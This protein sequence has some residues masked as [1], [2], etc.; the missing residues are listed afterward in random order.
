VKAVSRRPFVL[1]EGSDQI[2]EIRAHANRLQMMCSEL[3]AALSDLLDETLSIAGGPRG[4]PPALLSVQ[5]CADVLGLS[6][7]TTFSLIRQ[8]RL[9]SIKVGT[10]RLVPRTAIEQF[11]GAGTDQVPSIAADRRAV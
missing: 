3:A 7:T 8:G 4:N 9:Q 6:R 11:I 1:A 2:G 10:R 5:D